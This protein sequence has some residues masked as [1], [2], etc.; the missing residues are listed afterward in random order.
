MNR[1]G[2][3]AEGELL[4]GLTAYR[5]DETGSYVVHPGEEV[6]GFRML[7]VSSRCIGLVPNGR[8][9]R[10]L[11]RQLGADLPLEL[12]E[13]LVLAERDRD[14]GRDDENG[15]PGPCENRP[16]PATCSTSEL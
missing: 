11:S 3:S 16:H 8:C 14:T 12:F 5:M 1:L 7:P 9:R 15:Q 4:H 13:A 6:R 2:P 10:V